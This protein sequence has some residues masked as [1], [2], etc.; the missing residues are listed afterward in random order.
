MS[1]AAFEAG[2]LGK[3]LT[4]WQYGLASVSPRWNVSGTY[5]QVIPRFVSVDEDGNEYEFLSE[6]FGKD[7]KRA[8]SLVFRKGY[9][10]PFDCKKALDGSSLI[11]LLVYREKMLRGR[12]VYLDF[13][14]NP[15][16]IENFTADVLD[17]EGANYLISAKADFGTPIE[18]LR[19]M[20]DPAYQ[21][22]LGKGVDLEREMLEISLSAQHNN[23]G[24]DVDMWWQT[25]VKGLFAAGEVAGTHGS[26]LNAGQVGGTRAAQYIARC[27]DFSE[28]EDDE[29]FAFAKDSYESFS[30]LCESIADGSES[31]IKALREEVTESMSLSGAAI[32]NSEK[33]AETLEKA[34]ET[35]KNYGKIAKSEK[36]E[37]PDALR[38]RDT[39]AT[40]VVYLSAMLYYIENGGRSRGSAL[41]TSEKG[42]A[43]E[44]LDSIFAFELDSK[45]KGS[46]VQ[47]A[48]LDRESLKVTCAERAIRP[49]PE[50][51]GFFENEWKR[52]REDGNVY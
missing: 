21:L 20:N 24:I 41:Y 33:I 29:F 42:K 45:G 15:F 34:K 12:K 23:G 49:L 27:G 46:M 6:Y 40:Q 11:D 35:L 44:G 18:R 52:Y 9:Q 5:M 26:A 31:N 10:W 3:N 48:S 4:E 7:E 39:L 1:G 36:N 25:S 47:T 50:G 16:G 19:H 13:R 51:G 22:Y 32:R 37:L 30:M 17:E 38:L 28:I 43:P 14:K 8:L 2:A